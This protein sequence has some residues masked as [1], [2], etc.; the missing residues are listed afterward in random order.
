MAF[1]GNFKLTGQLN[2][3]FVK[4]FKAPHVWLIWQGHTNSYKLAD[5]LIVRIER[6]VN[7]NA[8]NWV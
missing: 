5:Q 8:R 1:I 7:K 4:L 3:L 6:T 2:H